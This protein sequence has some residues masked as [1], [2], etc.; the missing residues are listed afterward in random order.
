MW[1]FS[2]SCLICKKGDKL[3]CQDCEEKLPQGRPICPG[4]RQPSF[5]GKTHFVCQRRTYLDGLWAPFLYQK[6][7]K[8]IVKEFKFLLVKRWGEVMVDLLRK[9]TPKTLV[10]YWQRKKFVLSSLPLHSYRQR[11]RGFNQAAVLAEG[12]AKEWEL[13]KKDFLVR[14]RFALPQV[15]LSKKERKKNIQGQFL[16]KEKPSLRIILVDDVF[17]TGSS[18]NEAAKVLKKEGVKEVWGLVF[19][20]R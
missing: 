18:L 19:C 15:G 5:L 6:E 4:C 14:W 10:N 2:S 7:V 9:N 1:L 20:R 12:L 8:L 11:W 3:L 17:T 13:E 16:V